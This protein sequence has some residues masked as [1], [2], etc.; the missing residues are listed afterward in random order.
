[1]NRGA[2]VSAPGLP[3]SRAARLVRILLYIVAATFPS[4]VGA[5][6]AD[7]VAAAKDTVRARASLGSPDQVDN[8]LESDAQTRDPL[9]DFGFLDGYLGFKDELKESSGF[10]FGIDYTAAYFGASA[11]LEA[12]NAGSGILRLFGAWDLVGRESG[13]T[14]AFVYKI[15]HRHAY[16]DVTPK[17][18]GFNLGYAGMFAAPFND[19]GFRVTNLY[20]RQK[21][22]GG[23]FALLGGFL[24]ATDYVDIFGLG[25]PWLHFMNLA[26][27]T[28]AASIALPNDGLLGLAGA[29]WLSDHMYAIASIGDNGSDPTD[30]FSGFDRFF[31]VNEYFTSVEVGW[32]TAQDRAYFDNI[33]VTVWH[34]DEKSETGDPSGWG[35]NA[36]GT[37]LFENR[38]MPFLRGG[39]AKDGGSLLEASVSTGV[40][41]QWIPGRDVLGLGINW[42]KPNSTTWGEG[43]RDQYTVELFWRWQLGSQLAVTPDLQLLINPANNPDES[44]IWVFGVRGRFNL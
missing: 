26:F 44:S 43:L 21:L 42:G 7:S 41:Y 35:I 1:M 29:A 9:V 38:W 17:V 18:L 10:G 23:R 3:R 30:P 22:D 19:D 20:W 32:T 40:G 34:S 15:E 33:H 12:D 36:S 6:E 2:A 16:S 31:N 39:Y 25:S 27:S 11:G 4:A 24:D 8:Q 14:G 13:N 28:G 37:W 5:Q